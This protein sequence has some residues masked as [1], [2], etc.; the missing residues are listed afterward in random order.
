MD[1]YAPQQAQTPPLFAPPTPGQKVATDV[2]AGVIV[3]FI[4]WGFV[5]GAPGLGD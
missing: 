4:V 5:L 1:P 2:F 3:A